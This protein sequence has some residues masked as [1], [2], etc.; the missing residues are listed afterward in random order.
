MSKSLL[1]KERNFKENICFKKKTMKKKE[2][3]KYNPDVTNYDLDVLNNKTENIRNDEGRDNIL[4]DREK[5]VD[6]TGKDLDIPGRDVVNKS[7]STRLRDEENQLFSQG[8]EH[9]EN[10][11]QD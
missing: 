9:N 11:E 3:L 10:L 4:R 6:F 5:P 7:E 1:F 8:S 2:D